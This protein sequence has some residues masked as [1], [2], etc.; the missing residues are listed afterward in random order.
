MSN[1]FIRA[2]ICSVCLTLSAIAQVPFL[3]QALSPVSIAP[4]SD[5]FTLTVNGT[6]FTKSAYVS[7]DRSKRTTTFI[8][9]SQLQASI[10]ATD[11]ASAKTGWITVTNPGTGGGTSNVIFFPVTTDRSTLSFADTTPFDTED[12]VVVG[13]FNNDGKL[14]VVAAPQG[15]PTN[16]YLGNGKGGFES[17]IQVTLGSFTQ[18][19]AG[20]FNGDG[21]LDIAGFWDEE[22]YIYLGNGDGTF[23]QTFSLS[24]EPLEITAMAT[25]DFNGD[26]KLD[27]YISG[28][29]TGPDYFEIYNG[30]G[31]GTFT[32]GGSYYT[33]TAP[34]G[35]IPGIP[36]I[37]DFSGN[38]YLGLVI[39]GE[40]EDGV[41][42]VS[43]W[44]G[45]A[46]GGLTQVGTVSGATGGNFAAADLNNDG[47]LDVV[48][49]TGCV[50]LGN[51]NGTFS[52]CSY[53]S[54]TG[55][56]DGIGD[57]NGDGIPDLANDEVAI[58]LGAG[59]GTFPT[60]FT[61]GGGDGRPPGAIGDFNNDGLLD[62]VSSAGSV[63][64]QKTVVLAPANLLFGDQSVGTKST[65]Q[66]T[67]LT[68]IGT[69]SLTIDK[70][71]IT[72]KNSKQFLQTNDCGTSLAAGDSCTISVTFEPTKSGSFTPELSVTYKGAAS[73]QTVYLSGT[74]T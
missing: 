27:L 45:S 31:D 65:P 74:G 50:L 32:L 7:W 46:D 62:V 22:F 70:I 25:A 20:D 49:D 23:T 19:V 3:N 17:P 10:K 58:L 21:N 54:S 15:G 26:G 41:N 5:A 4:G 69:S 33:G 30:N 18:M 57:F 37:G 61:L 42:T 67:T 48:S 40:S 24:T 34:A 64:L 73:P 56:I 2:A 29:E 59:N 38:G 53:L 66:T 9:S 68:N 63:F 11:V 72:G 8:S 1:H 47:N 55:V 51:G 35:Y 6:G 43:V 39:G 60:V 12:V 36:A 16:L 71:S 28:W 52:S 44:S 14:D 13:D